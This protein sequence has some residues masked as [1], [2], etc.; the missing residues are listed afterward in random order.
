M[1]YKMF[2]CLFAMLFFVNPA[3]NTVEPVSTAIVIA[4][5]LATAIAA[6]YG[7]CADEDVEDDHLTPREQ[8]ERYVT[9][10]RAYTAAGGVAILTAFLYWLCGN[11]TDST[12][13][14]Q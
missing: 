2:L 10:T 14:A 4:G 3:I 1:N 7:K 12:D 5:S 8:H 6:G 9:R 13:K 11:K